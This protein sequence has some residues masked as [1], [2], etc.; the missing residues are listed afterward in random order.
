[1]RLTLPKF[2]IKFTGD[3]Y[4]NKLP[5]WLV[6]KP[7]HHKVKGYEI[8]KIIDIIQPGDI[9]LRR[10]DGYL[11]T[12]FIPGYWSHA[13]LYVD[14]GDVIHAIGIGVIKEDILDFCR[15]DAIT[16]LRIKNSSKEMINNAIKFAIKE[17]IDKIG[18][19]YQ[20]RDNN[21]KVYCTEL[22]NLCYNDIFREDF[23]EEFGN[24]TLSP[25][26]IFNSKK[27]DKVLVFKH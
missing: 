27:I 14:S 20:F 2:I 17:E 12:M 25:E 10:V 5:L 23:I 19:D 4:I 24:I 26:S 9:L 1:M 8:R 13:G 21:G 22:V 15:C 6:Y 3:L 16:I 18:Y 7:K 11:S